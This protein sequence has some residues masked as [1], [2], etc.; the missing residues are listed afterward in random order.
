[1]KILIFD[2]E[3]TGLPTNWNAK[4]PKWYKSWPY[5]VQLSWI[6]YDIDDDTYKKEDYII[7]LPLKVTIPEE[8]I[9]IH[10]ITNE[11]MNTQGVN[12]MKALTQ[13]LIHLQSAD[14]IVAHNLNFDKKMMLAEFARRNMVNHFELVHGIDYCTMRNSEELCG[15]T[16][17]SL[18][19]GL[20]IKKFPRLVELHYCLFKENVCNL[21]NAFNDVLVCLRCYYKL[22][23]D[24]DILTK[25]KAL[26]KEFLKNTPTS[27]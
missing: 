11:I 15:L 21:H 1:M 7:K 22:I 24:E 6:F 13:F 26:C 3:T 16:K 19:S 18:I 8:S 17:T 14:F 10:G 12:F 5:I 2:T 23:Y 25:N 27:R 9:K 4:G 20:P